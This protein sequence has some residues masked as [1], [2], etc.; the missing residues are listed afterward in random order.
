MNAELL[1]GTIAEH[2]LTVE[3]VSEALGMDRATFYRKLNRHNSF[4]IEQ[5]NT[6]IKLLHLTKR[7]INVLFFDPDFANSANVKFHKE[8]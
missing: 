6:L 3:E 8:G 1:K 2:N 7:E 4:S 5:V